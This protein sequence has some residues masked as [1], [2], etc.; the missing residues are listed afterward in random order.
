MKKGLLIF[1]LALAGFGTLFAQTSVTGVSMTAENKVAIME[2]FTGVRCT[3]C[4]DG[5]LILDGLLQ[6]YPT[7]LYAVSSHPQGSGLTAPY[8]GDPDLRR[9]YPDAFYSTPYCGTTRF[10]P[11]AFIN[12]RIWAGERLQGRSSW[13]TYVAELQAGFACECR[14]IGDV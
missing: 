13:G 3:Y 1:A 5:K 2:E 4:P 12:R 8:P 6:T 7:T 9:T 10:M 14:S 11:S